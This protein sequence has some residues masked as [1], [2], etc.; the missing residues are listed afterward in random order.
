MAY[1]GV[2]DE[3]GQKTKSQTA[4][5]YNLHPNRSRHHRRRRHRLL[6]GWRD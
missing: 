5:S 3:I 4:G 6:Q 1:G 2:Q